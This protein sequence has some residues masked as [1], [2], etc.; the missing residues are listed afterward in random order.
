M[1]DQT[2]DICGRT[3]ASL[4]LDV[5]GLWICETCRSRLM[6]QPVGEAE[7]DALDPELQPLVGKSAGA[8]CRTLELPFVP[9]FESVIRAASQIAYDQDLY[10]S[11]WL[12][13][14]Q[15]QDGTTVW[16]T[17][18][19]DATALVSPQGEVDIKK[20]GSA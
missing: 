19:G 2:C 17:A 10:M 15:W 4:E 6:T 20:R 8:I 14:T 18:E 5:D 9:P 16:R 12:F 7:D 11:A 13:V 1:P 3:Q